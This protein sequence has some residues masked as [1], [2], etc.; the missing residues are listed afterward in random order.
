[1][2]VP[3]LRINAVNAAPVRGDGEF[4]LYWMIA[5]RRRRANFALQRAVEWC[6]E[7]GKPLVVLEALRCDHR[8]ASARLHAFV[9]AGMRDNARD[10]AAAGVT[11]HPFVEQRRGAGKG[12]LASLGAR[13]AAVVTDE[14]PCFFLPAMVRAA[15][16]QLPVRLEQV[17]GYGLLPLRA[18]ER[19][20]ARAVDFRRFLQRT[21]PPHLREGPAADPLRGQLPPS[22]PLPAAIT[23]R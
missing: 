22:R 16:A 15:G 4:V 20:F 8:W 17:D 11:Y 1:M 23:R 19:V 2:K 21:L 18:A 14:F 3:A 12:L 10:F 6:R 9:L 7:L 5:A 13:A